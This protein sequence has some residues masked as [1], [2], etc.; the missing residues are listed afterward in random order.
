MARRGTSRVVGV[1]VITANSTS[2][3]SSGRRNRGSCPAADEFVA[4]RARHLRQ[5]RMRLLTVANRLVVL[6]S[7]CAQVLKGAHRLVIT[8]AN[9]Q[10]VFTGANRLV[11][12]AGVKKGLRC[13][14]LAVAGWSPSTRKG[15]GEETG[16]NRATSFRA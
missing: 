3:S 5:R 11:V 8:G 14:V 7:R 15:G 1:V 12:L 9:R 4:D 6:P 10:V 2:I 13:L 16:P